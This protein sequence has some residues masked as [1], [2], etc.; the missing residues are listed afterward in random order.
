M[1]LR[2][3]APEFRDSALLFLF[4]FSWFFNDFTA[5]LLLLFFWP[6]LKESKSMRGN[7]W[8]WFAYFFLSFL[9]QCLSLNS[10]FEFEMTFH[11]SR[12]WTGRPENL[13][14]PL[15]G[16]HNQGG[17]AHHFWIYLH[18]TCPYFL[19]WIHLG[20]PKRIYIL[21][22]GITGNWWSTKKQFFFNDQE[23]LFSYNISHKKS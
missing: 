21:V 2:V 12:E 5:I 1:Q 18:L 11:L 22:T 17:S 20:P 15:S 10:S 9:F 7:F 19:A 4:L 23:K 3:S 8:S 16:V 6:R 13:Q 14:F